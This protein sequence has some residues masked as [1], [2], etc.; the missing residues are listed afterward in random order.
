[1]GNLYVKPAKQGN[2]PYTRSGLPPP[3]LLKKSGSD[4]PSHKIH[5]PMSLEMHMAD[6]RTRTAGLSDAEREWRR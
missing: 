6:E 4:A 2:N 5:D 3:K 1:M